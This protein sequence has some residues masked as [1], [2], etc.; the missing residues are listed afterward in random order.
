MIPSENTGLV[1]V[2]ASLAAMWV[3]AEPYTS[4]A[5]A[6]AA[7][8]A[9]DQVQAIAP[10]L[11]MSEVASALYKRLRRGEL[12]LQ[13]AVE[14]LHVVY[15]FGV[16]LEGET[17]LHERALFLAQSLDRSA[18]YDALY[19]ALAEHRGCQVWTGIYALSFPISP[20]AI[21]VGDA[22]PPGPSPGR[23]QRDRP[24][25]WGM[26]ISC[27]PSAAKPKL[28]IKIHYAGAAQ[29]TPDLPGPRTPNILPGQPPD[30]R[31]QQVVYR[32]NWN[33]SVITA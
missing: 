14:A 32:R 2:D 5:L 30:I 31:R 22:C 20:L 26:R 27:Q 3:M 18:P 25:R 1:V 19:L 8:W 29:N 9:R 11:M 13:Q 4:Q 7:D 17:G 33:K 23:P 12:T 15:S 16:R 10:H 21:Y 28:F 6:L 24:Y